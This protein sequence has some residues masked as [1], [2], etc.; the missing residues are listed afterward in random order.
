MGLAD[1]PF[2][3]ANISCENP[4]AAARTRIG[5]FRSVSN[6]PRAFAVQSMVGEI[7]QATGRDQKDMQDRRRFQGSRGSYFQCLLQI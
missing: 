5:W 2:E 4:E 3:I 7:A 6:I 1:L